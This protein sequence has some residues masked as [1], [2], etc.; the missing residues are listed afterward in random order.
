VKVRFWGVRGSYPVPGPETNRYG[1]NTSCVEVRVSDDK[2]S[3][4]IIIDAGTG[5]R[6]LGKEMMQGEFAE[7]R[8]A[9]HLLVS[10]THWDHIQGLPFFAPVYQ[11]GNKFFVYARQR[12]DT[13]LRAVF[14]SQTESEYFPVPFDKAQAEV[15][16][17]ELVEGARFEIGP[18]KVACARLNH[19]YVAIGYRLD[20]EGH[21]VAYVTDT[22]P[23]TDILIENEFIATPPQPGDPLKPDDASKLKAMRD[24]VVRL[25]E[26]A[27]VV[28]YDTQFT[29]E[30]YRSKPHWGHSC[31]EDAIEIA[32]SAG[33][34]TV[35]L[36]HHA[37]ERTD[38]QIDALLAQHRANTPDLQLVAAAEGMELTL[39]NMD[40]MPAPIVRA[41]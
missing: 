39:S 41:K 13:H 3:P 10:H 24:G 15:A 16:F 21:S 37:P 40:A 18:V 29:P 34:K 19:P 36:F 35:V 12:D 4:R 11:K 2:D 9:A 6:K 32:R 38:D 25:C 31:P 27:D 20:Y 17:R 1:G 5:L 7:G 28:I 14:A 30:E 8:G 22:A 26:G 23:F 33:A